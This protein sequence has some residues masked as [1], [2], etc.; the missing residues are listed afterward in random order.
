M[1]PDVMDAAVVGLKDE[2]EGELP[3]AF[4]VERPGSNLTA[5]SVKNFMSDRVSFPSSPI[6]FFLSCR[7]YRST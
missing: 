3:A 7:F 5:D 1:H 6:I 2:R 4:V